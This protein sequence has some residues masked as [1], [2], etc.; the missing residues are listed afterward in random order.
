MKQSLVIPSE[1][2]WGRRNVDFSRAHGNED[3]AFRTLIE[4]LN[5]KTGDIIGDIMS[6]Y[7]EVSR[8]V[9]EY[10]AEKGVFAKTVLIDAYET[11]I[12]KSYEHLAKFE[13]QGFVVERLVQDA[14]CISLDSKFDKAVIKMGLHE[15]SRTDQA[16]ILEKSYEALKPAGELYVWESMG[17]TPEVTEWFRKIV[18]K[19]DELAGFQSFVENRDFLYDT[20]IIESMKKVGFVGV[21]EVYF[22][23]FR[24]I[25]E[26][27]IGDFEG[28]YRKVEEWN[29]YLR[30]N[31]PEHIKRA[32]NF[33]DNGN[34]ISMSFV[35][36]IFRGKRIRNSKL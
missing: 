25:T 32:I 8:K 26:N 27:L 6:G 16:R 12:R 20:E 28:D 19:K 31:V 21:L 11:Q 22:G 1:E 9:L 29:K 2:G 3:D 13:G 7:G 24:Y 4:Q 35:K 36:K 5:V 15:V 14:R 23:E 33:T 18:R 17:Q 34:S 30:M 10:C